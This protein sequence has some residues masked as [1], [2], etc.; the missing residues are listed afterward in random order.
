MQNKLYHMHA[1]L[2]CC[3]YTRQQLGAWSACAPAAAFEERWFEG[4]HRWGEG[5]RHPGENTAGTCTILKVAFSCNQRLHLHRH[6]ARV[7]TPTPP[8][9]TSHLVPPGGGSWRPG[10]PLTWL[11][12]W[13]LEAHAACQTQPEPRRQTRSRRR[14][15]GARRAWWVLHRRVSSSRT[16][17]QNQRLTASRRSPAPCSRRHMRRSCAAPGPQAKRTRQ[18]QQ[19]RRPSQHRAP[20]CS[21]AARG[22]DC[23]LLEWDH[24]LSTVVFQSNANEMQ[25]CD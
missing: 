8:A 12:C 14:A 23:D 17:W 10:W 3:R 22:G 1:P 9:A 6:D 25:L 16:G 15:E 13:T 7:A 19:R 18:G 2:C 20:L 4:G 11:P 24:D 21:T 5:K